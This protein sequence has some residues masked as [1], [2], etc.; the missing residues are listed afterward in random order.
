MRLRSHPPRK[1]DALRQTLP[2]TLTLA[3]WTGIVLSCS[4]TEAGEGRAQAAKN[5]VQS[6][7]WPDTERKTHVP[8]TARCAASIRR[9]SSTVRAVCVNALVRICAGA[10]SDDRPYRD[11][12]LGRSGAVGLWGPSR[13]RRR[14]GTF[15]SRPTCCLPGQGGV[16]CLKFL[17][18]IGS[19]ILRAWAAGFGL[20]SR[21]N[22]FRCS[23]GLRLGVVQATWGRVPD[24]S[25]M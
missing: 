11:S 3:V 20:H 21:G 22:W 25:G 18:R 1:P 9:H 10:I 13:K 23:S 24:K 17:V 8:G 4:S 7:M 6:H 15:L 14:K 2:P 16:V 5:I 12:Y 19:R